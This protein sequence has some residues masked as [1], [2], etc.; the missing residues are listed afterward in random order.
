MKSIFH[1][2][3]NFFFFQSDYY[4]ILNDGETNQKRIEENGQVVLVSEFD[5]SLKN[6]YKV[7][8]G[9]P[10]KLLSQL[11]DENFSAG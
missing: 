7:I 9:T 5:A 8:R 1:L 3:K 10:E 2:L 6:G 11:V 4:K